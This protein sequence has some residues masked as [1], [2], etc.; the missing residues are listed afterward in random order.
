[1]H[2]RDNAWAMESSS[3]ERQQRETWF[4]ERVSPLMSKMMEVGIYLCWAVYTDF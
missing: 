1:M 4:S 2:V 3:C